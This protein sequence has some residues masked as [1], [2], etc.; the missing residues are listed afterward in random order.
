VTRA[1]RIAQI[2]LHVRAGTY[3]IDPAAVAEAML[4]RSQDL[5][6]QFQEQ[7]CEVRA[8]DYN[9]VP[10]QEIAETLGL[11]E[12]TVARILDRHYRPGIHPCRRAA[13]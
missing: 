9:G 6:M 8:L 10:Q 12:G 4:N 11:D 5:G 3:K 13:A 7:R 1:E 2:K